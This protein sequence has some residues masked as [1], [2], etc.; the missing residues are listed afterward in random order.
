MEA[1]TFFKNCALA[2]SNILDLPLELVLEVIDYLSPVDVACLAL[3]N[4]HLFTRLGSVLKDISKSFNLRLQLLQ[5]ACHELE[6][7]Y[8]CF[9]CAKLHLWSQVQP[10]GEVRTPPC[11]GR[12]LTEEMSDSSSQTLWLG[13]ENVML[14][15][16]HVQ[17]A[18]R[19]AR[20]GP[21]F[22]L[23]PDK[24]NFTNISDLY[25]RYE[26]DV[27]LSSRSEIETT[28]QFWPW[29]RSLRSG[30]AASSHATSG[31]QISNHETSSHEASDREVSI[32]AAPGDQT[33]IHDPSNRDTSDLETS[34]N[35]A[36]DD[37][38]PNDEESNDED[39]DD[40]ESNN[41]KSDDEESERE[42]SSDEGGSEYGYE[43]REP[44]RILTSVEAAVSHEAAG[45]SLCLRIQEVVAMKQDD[46]WWW[47]FKGPEIISDLI[48]VCPHVDFHQ[49]SGDPP[50]QPNI[51]AYDVFHDAVSNIRVDDDAPPTRFHH[52][53]SCNTCWRFGI[54][55]SE[56]EED[57]YIVST[58]WLDL[59]LGLTPEDDQW[60]V[61]DPSFQSLRTG[62]SEH[63][64]LPDAKSRF[65]KSLKNGL[66]EKELL[67]RNLVLVDDG[68]C[69]QR[70]NVPLL[71]IDPPW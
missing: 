45:P 41:E 19:H 40:D 24:L 65:E 71:S 46:L 3:C 56:D 67:K 28:F 12:Q 30:D 8:I 50:I 52:C 62:L 70:G 11:P 51:Y 61:H 34:E 63:S 22:G 6:T 23:K 27:S 33:S 55:A 1:S 4:S 59:G 53:R 17:L 64:D 18:M 68:R 7:H 47:R 35:E 26:E 69:P 37:E 20:H 2:N 43:S 39:S 31:E 21:S 9:K 54:R 57:Y 14:D 10:P 66:S 58:R 49:S 36:P 13:H 48:P 42:T 60:K 38:E 16:T 32:H 44:M 25:F 5:R 29:W 15:F